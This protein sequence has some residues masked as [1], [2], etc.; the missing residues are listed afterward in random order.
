MGPMLWV[1]ARNRLLT[2]VRVVNAFKSAAQYRLSEAQPEANA[3][4]NAN[5]GVPV[6]FTR[7]RYVSGISI[8]H[9]TETVAHACIS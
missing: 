4:A 9:V 2:Q 3:N 5:A 1:R 7:Q 8:G 6:S